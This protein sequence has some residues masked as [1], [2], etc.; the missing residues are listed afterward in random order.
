MRT[1]TTGTARIGGLLL[2]CITILLIAAN[3]AAATSD[4]QQAETHIQD[5]IPA[6]HADG[7]EPVTESDESHV[8]GSVDFSDELPVDIAEIRR[9]LSEFSPQEF[10]SSMAGSPCWWFFSSGCEN[11]QGSG[12]HS[13]GS[14]Y[15]S[16][17][18]YTHNYNQTGYT[19]IHVVPT[20]WLRY[21]AMDI[22]YVPAYNAMKN[23]IATYGPSVTVRSW[24][25]I[26]QQFLCHAIGHGIGAGPAWDL[27]GH[28]TS[29]WNIAT[30]GSTLCNW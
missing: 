2:A 27:E 1:L 29:T 22:E 21:M 11:G 4:L 6:D 20:F 9:I 19:R 28:R 3:P 26:K 15:I 5:D 8:E 30:W 25:T 14:L 12:Y 7:T 23:C 13:C 16:E 17:I 18:G 24:S 10:G